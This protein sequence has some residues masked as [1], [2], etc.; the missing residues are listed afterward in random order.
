[1]N[2][3]KIAM[4]IN[5]MR[6]HISIVK[7][8][9]CFNSIINSNSKLVFFDGFSQSLINRQKIM[10]QLYKLYYIIYISFFGRE[11]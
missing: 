2:I 8:Q 7:V 1:M 9:Q 11:I 6:H 5:E 10:V 4:T 3:I